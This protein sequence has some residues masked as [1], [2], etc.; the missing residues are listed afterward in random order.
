[1]NLLTF[2]RKLRYAILRMQR[3]YELKLMIN[4]KTLDRIV[5]DDHYELKHSASINDALIVE[6]VKSLNGRTY[7]HE[8]VTLAGWEIY[9]LDPLVFAGKPYRF[10]WCLHPDESYIG[11]INAFRRKMKYA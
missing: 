11:V 9:T 7:L 3:S 1:M 8:F 6:I 2:K 10:V 5:I 4:G